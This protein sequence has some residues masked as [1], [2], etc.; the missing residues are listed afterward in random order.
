MNTYI[1]DNGL[2]TATIRTGGIEMEYARFGTGA[3]PF[4]ILPG[5]SLKSVIPSAATV[6]EAY[7]AFGEDH[8]VY[9]FDRRKHAPE[10]YTV[11]NMAEETAAVMDALG[12]RDADV[13]GASQG[14]MIALY[15]A[16]GRPE[17]VHR[18]ALGSTLCRPNAV[19]NA[20]VERWIAL[21]Q[22]GDVEAL[23]R[24]SVEMTYAP[25]TAAA[26]GEVFVRANSNLSPEE[27]R[28][29]LVMARA[30]AGMDC[31]AD[32]KKIRCPVLVIGAGG[33]RIA[34]ADASREI[35]EQL[36]CEAYFYGTEYGHAVYDEA[37]DYRER[38]LAFF[39]K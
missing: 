34:T 14:G 12:L 25:A 22:A 35:A 9:L 4:V 27:L 21:A 29:F 19:S 28:T 7:A 36:G 5:L 32:L 38:L 23:V 3:R 37:P 33:D 20:V 15:L 17:L 6:A 39:R 2:T 16:I 10:G 30:G 8:T 11:R 24:D 13:F 26:F 1:L 31:Y 18:M